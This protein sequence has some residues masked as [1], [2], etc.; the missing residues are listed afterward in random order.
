MCRLGTATKPFEWI[1]EVNPLEDKVKRLDTYKTCTRWDIID[2]RAR[3]EA[4]AEGKF[5]YR[6]DPFVRHQ[7]I[8]KIPL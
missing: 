4:L 1:D 5:V 8:A 6:T 7:A 2:D 3:R